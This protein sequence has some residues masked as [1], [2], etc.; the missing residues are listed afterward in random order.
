M[1]AA[2]T[3]WGVR[4]AAGRARPGGDHVSWASVTSPNDR[5]NELR[6]CGRRR[7]SAAGEHRGEPGG[8]PLRVA[9]VPGSRNGRRR[10]LRR[11][12]GDLRERAPVQL[13]MRAAELD[14]APGGDQGF[15]PCARAPPAR[16]PDCS[17]PRQR[18]DDARAPRDRRPRLRPGRARHS[19]RCRVRSAPRDCP[20]SGAG[21]HRRRAPPRRGARRARARSLRSAPP[22]RRRLPAIGPAAAPPA[23]N[24][25]RAPRCDRRYRVRLLWRRSSPERSASSPVFRS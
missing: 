1:T 16:R 25:R 3:G 6:V 13:G 7:R 20:A 15:R 9:S 2:E 8:R 11:C 4:P 14:R 21:W 18:R 12:A 23:P 22:S 5:R 19:G 24:G 10:R 17:T